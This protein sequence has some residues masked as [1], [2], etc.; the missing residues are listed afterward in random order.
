MKIYDI[1]KEQNSNS[2]NGLDE[3]LSSDARQELEDY[4]FWSLLD[5]D[6]LHKKHALPIAHKMSELKTE[7]KLERDK[8]VD[9]WMPM[10]KEGCMAYYKE[11]R[12]EGDPKDL[13][14]KEMRKSL[15][16]RL[17]DQYYNDVLNDEYQ[18]G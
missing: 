5:H 2:K 13:F 4:V 10:V 3:K 11:N 6:H 9:C 15:C 12:L 14:P 1:L 8:F 18:V 7:D 16:H 17:A